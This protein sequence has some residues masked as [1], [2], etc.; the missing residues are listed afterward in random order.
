MR[1]SKGERKV[2]RSGDAPGV[3]FWMCDETSLVEPHAERAEALLVEEPPR[4]GQR[5]GLRLRP[6]AL[7]DVPQALAGLAA[8]DRDLAAAVE[9]LQHPRELG[10][11][12]P[13][14]GALVGARRH[15]ARARGR[16]AGRAVQLA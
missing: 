3:G 11:G 7:G 10:A 4:L 12:A 13:P 16:A 5:H 15:G 1:R 14:G 6:P 8:R 2:T 9:E